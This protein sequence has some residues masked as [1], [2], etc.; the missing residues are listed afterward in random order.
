MPLHICNK[1]KK[2]IESINMDPG[3]IF[4]EALGLFFALNLSECLK[5]K[6]VWISDTFRFW[7][8]NGV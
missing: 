2:K 4:I 6:L 7:T 1:P 8:H 3:C 5:S